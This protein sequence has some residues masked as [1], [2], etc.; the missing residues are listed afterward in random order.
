MNMSCR[1]RLVVL[2]MLLAVPG[3]AA[4]VPS[5][6]NPVT[7]ILTGDAVETR[8]VSEIP[9]PAIR[10]LLSM[11]KVRPGIA[12]AGE[13]FNATDVVW[14]NRAMRRLVLARGNSSSW[15]VY[16][17]HGGRSLHRHLVVLSV[18][19]DSAE[20]LCIGKVEVEADDFAAF[21]TANQRGLVACDP[22]PK[23]PEL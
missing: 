8:K 7:A 19:H 18:A 17:E 3:L 20:C 13:A 22:C 23:D 2:P 10:R 14:P 15:L 5:A 1:L 16:Y 11:M 6:K 21:R 9:A 12:S 4:S